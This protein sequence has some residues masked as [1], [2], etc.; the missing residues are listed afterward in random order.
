MEGTEHPVFIF[1]LDKNGHKA[2]AVGSEIRKR[3]VDG[4]LISTDPEVAELLCKRIKLE[5]PDLEEVDEAMLPG[6]ECDLSMGEEVVLEQEEEVVTS[7]AV[8]VDDHSPLESASGKTDEELSQEALEISE[9]GVLMQHMDIREPLSTL[10]L[11]LEQRLGVELTDYQFW[12]QD[13]QMLE[14][15]KN[16]V[17]QCVQGEGMVQINVQIKVD[18]DVKK[19]NIVDVLKPA[20]EYVELAGDNYLSPSEKKV[21]SP[22]AK[23]NVIRWV[24]DGQ[25]KKDQER[26]KIPGDPMEWEVAHV[27]H[28][29]QWAVR[30][31]NLVGIQLYD[32]NISG[33]QLCEMTLPDFQQRVPMDPNDLF[34]THLELLRKCKFV[35]VNQKQE[36]NTQVVNKSDN[37][38]RGRPI[39]GAKLGKL[40]RI[41]GLPLN[42]METATP[43]GGNRTGNNGQIQLWQFLLELLTDKEYRDVIQ[44][45]GNDGEFKLNNPEMVAQLWGERKNKPTMNYEKLSRA[46]RY[47]ERDLC[48]NLSVT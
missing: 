34:W 45:L 43:N 7:L 10:K 13:A 1:K 22:E 47:M 6:A 33:R 44:W 19:I 29:L 18:R 14:S 38:I 17:D 41:I 21:P 2:F 48:T 5:Q 37:T 46:L 23:Q 28:W 4:E 39:K 26:L 25:F 27:R 35:A 3:F 11:L 24:V 40:P 30:Q 36:Q 16:L 12:L 42:I 31:F 32:W 8:S 9:S 20:E 15:H